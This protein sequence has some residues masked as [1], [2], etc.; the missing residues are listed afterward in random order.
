M[1]LADESI[2]NLK[3]MNHSAKVFDDIVERTSMGA[4]L[5]EFVVP[6]VADWPGWFNTKHLVAALCIPPTIIPQQGL[7]H[8][9]IILEDQ[10]TLSR[11]LYA[12]LFDFIFG[13][14][15]P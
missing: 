1:A 12:L 11:F 3:I 9:S 5:N 7:F 13:L 14:V 10:V 6:F 15:F 4:Y 2:K 8:D